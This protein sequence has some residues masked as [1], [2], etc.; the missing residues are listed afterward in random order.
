VSNKHFG[1]GRREVDG[2]MVPCHIWPQKLFLDRFKGWDMKTEEDWKASI[3]CFGGPKPSE[4]E[5]YEIKPEMGQIV[6][7]YWRKHVAD[8]PIITKE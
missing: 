4:I 7:L 6:I 2:E 8:K 3:W 1:Q 5:R